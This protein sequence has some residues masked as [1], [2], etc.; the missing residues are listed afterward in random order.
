MKTLEQLSINNTYAE[1]PEVFCSR[2]NTTPQA[3]SAPDQ[4]LSGHACMMY[5][6]K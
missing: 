5:D 1:L 3:G 4:F 6:R 2:L